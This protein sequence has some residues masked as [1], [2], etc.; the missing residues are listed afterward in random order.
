MPAI[1]HHT[2]DPFRLSAYTLLEIVNRIDRTR[3]HLDKAGR[4]PTVHKLANELD[5]IREGALRALREVA[6]LS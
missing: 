4:A 5:T 2:P 6:K 3:A 1:K